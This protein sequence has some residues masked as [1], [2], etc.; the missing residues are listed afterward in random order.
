VEFGIGFERVI[1]ER[2]PAGHKPAAPR[3]SL[4]WSR[5]VPA[6]VSDYFAIQGSDLSWDDQT[7]FF[8]RARAGFGESDGPDSFEIMRAVDEQGLLNAIVVAYWT[9]PVRHARWNARSSLPIWFRRA[10]RVE[11][12]NG[13]WREMVSVPFERHE[14]IYSES[15][16]RIGAGRTEDSFIGPAVA[17]G[18]FGAA[19]DRLPISA[20]DPLSSPFPDVDGPSEGLRGFGQRLRVRAPVNMVTLRSGQYWEHA[21]EEQLRDYEQNMRPRLMTGMNHLVAHKEETGTLSL[22]VMTNLEDDGWERK[23]TSVLAHFISLDHLEQWSASHKT[24]LDIYSHAIAM[25]RHYKE[26]RKFV[27]WHELSVI[28]AAEFEYVNC[29]PRTGLMP[30]LRAVEVV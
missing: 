19:R 7:G 28:Q 23:E 8:G 17:N 30:R 12:R 21:D 15:F 16:Y 4:K 25:N 29:D 5:P 22:L 18:Y 10:E 3:Y 6:I 20:V 27:S 26:Q 2:R 24:H 14:T 9:D 1:P 11:E 13:Y